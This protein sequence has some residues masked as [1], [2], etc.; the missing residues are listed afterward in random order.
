MAIYTICEKI[1]LMRVF[2]Q[3]FSRLNTKITI[4]ITKFS[5][6]S[7]ELAIHYKLTNNLID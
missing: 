5:Y 4:K 3:L 7:M 6:M 1:F 2:T